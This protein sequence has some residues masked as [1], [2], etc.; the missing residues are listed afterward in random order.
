M[1]FGAFASPCLARRRGPDNYKFAAP[2]W[3]SGPKENCEQFPPTPRGVP[4]VVQHV[5]CRGI[6]NVIRSQS[7][8]IDLEEHLPLGEVVDRRAGVETDIAKLVAVNLE[9]DRGARHWTRFRGEGI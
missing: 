7:E 9:V 2:P 8:S 4:P 5:S 1:S 6:G 3:P